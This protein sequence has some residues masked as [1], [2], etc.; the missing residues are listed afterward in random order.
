MK[1]KFYV[2]RNQRA[3][4]EIIDRLPEVGETY[5]GETVTYIQEITPDVDT[6]IAYPDAGAYSFYLIETT[7]EDGDAFEDYVAILAPYVDE[8][9]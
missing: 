6:S 2:T 1:L 8:V 3:T 9:Q 7:D 5:N 4:A